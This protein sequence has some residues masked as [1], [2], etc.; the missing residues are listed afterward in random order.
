MIHLQERL[1]SR[2]RAVARASAPTLG[3][4]LGAVRE[5]LKNA[6]QLELSTIPLYLY[7][8]Y[9]LRDDKEG[10]K[11]YKQINNPIAKRLRSVVI[12]EM[13]HM[14]LACN[15]LKAVGGDPSLDVL[16]TSKLWPTYPGPLPGGIGGQLTV[17]LAPFS[18][19]QLKPFLKIEEPEDRLDFPVARA[20][21]EGPLTIG[22]FYTAIRQSIEKI[23]PAAFQDPR[24]EKQIGPDLT[25]DYG[26]SGAILV[27]DV[28]TAKQAINTIIDQ[29]EGTTQSPLEAADSGKF[30]HYYRFMEIQQGKTLIKNPTP[31]SQEPKDQYIYAGKDKGGADITFNPDGVVAGLRTNP[32]LTDYEGDKDAHDKCGKFNENYTY[33]LYSIGDSYYSL[34]GYGPDE[35]F[36][37]A[38]QYMYKLRDLAAEMMR[39]VPCVSP[40]FEAAYWA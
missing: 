39:S 13:L 6:I 14:L 31:P 37:D 10:D 8:L 11:D 28:E 32:K 33:L 21:A 17:N 29:G 40:S 1:F 5:A 23:G 27:K 38:M 18:M 34:E 4:Q 9:S 35:C 3:D 19:E 15:V 20:A 12:E 25:E 2:L 30:A 22:Q 7:A 24:I 26:M 16:Y 36:P